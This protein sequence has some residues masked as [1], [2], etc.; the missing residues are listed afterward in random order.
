M[1]L[2]SVIQ[3]FTLPAPLPYMV[4][5]WSYVTLDLRTLNCAVDNEKPTSPH[6]PLSHH[7]ALTKSATSVLP[8]TVTCRTKPANSKIRLYHRCVR[9]EKRY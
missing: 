2:V 6:A 5:L 1:G 9:L 7:R 4:F 8:F 3:T